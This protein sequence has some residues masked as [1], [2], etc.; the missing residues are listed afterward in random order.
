MKTN[1]NYKNLT[2]ASSYPL[3]FIAK[4]KPLLPRVIDTIDFSENQKRSYYLT[5]ITI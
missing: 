4:N 2:E 5:E 3:L 1:H